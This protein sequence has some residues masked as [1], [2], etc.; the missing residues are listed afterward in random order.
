MLI[1]V[2]DAVVR[3]RIWQGGGKVKDD[4]LAGG[5]KKKEGVQGRESLENK[6]LN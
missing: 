1:V 3:A 2:D 5:K 4:T 6:K